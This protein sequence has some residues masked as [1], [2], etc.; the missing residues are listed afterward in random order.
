MERAVE[1]LRVQIR[2]EALQLFVARERL[3]SFQEPL[4]VRP[5]KTHV[6]A[7]RV[8]FGVGMRVVLAVCRNPADRITLERESPK[9]R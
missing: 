9:D 7:V 4:H 8:A 6:P 3:V 5:R 2:C 1:F